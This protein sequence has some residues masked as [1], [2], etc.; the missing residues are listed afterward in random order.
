MTREEALRELGVPAGATA[1]SVRAAYMKLLRER[2]PD[3][4][5]AGFQRLREAYELLRAPSVVVESPEP[6][7]EKGELHRILAMGGADAPSP[8]AKIR[9]L[10]AALKNSPDDLGLV[11]WLIRELFVAGFAEPAM[12]QAASVLMGPRA[13][14]NAAV[15]VWLATAELFP[16]QL[17]VSLLWQASQLDSAPLRLVVLEVMVSSGHITMAFDVMASLLRYPTRELQPLMG[18][19]LDLLMVFLVVN[20]KRAGPLV[21][22]ALAISGPEQGALLMEVRDNAKARW[23]PRAVQ[24]ALPDHLRVAQLPA[25]AMAKLPPEVAERAP[26]LMARVRTMAVMPSA[27]RVDPF[28]S[29]DRVLVG[30]VIG[31][32][33]VGFLFFLWHVFRGVG[34]R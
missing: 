23:L 26:L 27:E 19:L 18:R 1:Q 6:T 15:P 25:N 16:Q 13:R 30:V 17:N 20:A 2:K 33:I 9:V 4:D 14:T 28:A 12:A 8:M 5:P 34:G 22:A 32:L 29:R 24:C 21:E 3:Q 31:G 10:E 7:F 11:A